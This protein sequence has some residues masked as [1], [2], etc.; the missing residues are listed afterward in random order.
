M[1]SYFE[2]LIIVKCVD[3]TGFKITTGDL[4]ELGGEGVFKH[5]LGQG[6][7]GMWQN[8]LGGENSMGGMN[9]VC[10]F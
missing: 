10:Y 4:G 8:E 3:T 6:K 7:Y 9:G 1:Y 2:H 5:C